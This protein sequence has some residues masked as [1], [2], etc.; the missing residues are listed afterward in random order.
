M[1]RK[2]EEH[3]EKFTK[4]LV[5]YKVRPTI[6]DP[7]WKVGA[8]GLGMFSAALGKKATMACTEAVEEVIIDHYEKQSK[9]LEGKDDALSKVTKKFASDEKEH[10]HIAKD[11]GTGSDLLHQ[12]LK[13]GIKLISKI[14]IK[15]SERV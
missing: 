10:M 13:S 4:L 7:V 8:F 6:L 9:Y 5:Q 1:E 15:V 2:E 12:T 3:C 14:A 11:M